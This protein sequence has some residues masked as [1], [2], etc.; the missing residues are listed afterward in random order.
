M[1]MS[2]HL[3]AMTI[4]TLI[5]AGLL[6]AQNDPPRAPVAAPP[7]SRNQGSAQQGDAILATWLLVANNNE[8]ALAR[9][10]LQKAQSDEVKQFAQTMIDEHGQFALKLQP[11]ADSGTT[12]DR[13]APAGDK[14]K[15]DK[16]G[17]RGTSDHGD[18]GRD[19]GGHEPKDASGARPA[20]MP[21]AFDHVGLI[22]D[23]GRKCLETETKML[24]EKAGAD[25]DRCYIQMQVGAHVKM[26]DMVE[27]FR[28]RASDRLRPTLD[29]G[30]KTIQAHVARA[31]ALCEKCDKGQMGE[32]V[33]SSK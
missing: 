27:V 33:G 4:L 10:A 26:A 28:T 29:A 23:L 8:I 6:R 15:K 5:P 22:R 24:G 11:F 25:F 16:K 31:K 19:Q 32:K 7:D 30:Q 14:D 18:A 20:S 9:L 12:V 21:G 13:D 1:K 17:E 3:F 2:H